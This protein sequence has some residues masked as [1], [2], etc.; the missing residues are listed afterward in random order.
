MTRRPSITSASNPRLKALRRLRRRGSSEVFLAEGYRQ[1]RHALTAGAEVRELYSARDLHLGPAEARVVAEAACRGAD[2]VELAAEAFLSIA[3]RARPDGLLAVLG[4]PPTVLRRLD[5]GPSALVAVLEGLD[6][7]GNLGT[8]V[9]SACAARADA[10]VTC[11]ARASLFHPD[12][13]H[14]SVGA[15]FRVPLA[16][17]TT[18]E[19]LG[20]LRANAVRIV[21]ASPEG[22]VPYWDARLAG[23]V[24]LVFGNERGG[25]SRRWLDAADAAVAI[26]MGGGM[27]SLNVAV[28]AGIVL[29]EA[30]RQR[31][32]AAGVS[33][34]SERRT[35]S[36]SASASSSGG[37]AAFGIA[38]TRIPAARALRMPLCESSTAAQRSGG[39]P[40]RRAAS[41]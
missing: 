25:V 12:T 10:L 27:D 7:P 22:K 1:I 6:R 11:D 21:V 28:A 34:A 37:K 41:R 23:R 3:G 32:I 36:A 19:T 26:P 18:E 20:W 24:A 2:V 17:A 40:R 39:T 35:T 5:L 31:S 8:I 33:S 9:R 13:V 14:G 4:R 15:V 30:A 29:F 16:E 38:T